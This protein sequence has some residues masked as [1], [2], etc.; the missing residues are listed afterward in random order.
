MKNGYFFCISINETG[1]KTTKYFS[2]LVKVSNMLTITDR[3]L[4]TNFIKL[5]QR[6]SHVL[7]NDIFSNQVT[8]EEVT[9]YDGDVGTIL[10]LFL[11][12]GKELILS[13]LEGIETT[14]DLDAL[15]KKLTALLYKAQEDI[16][17]YDF[18]DVLSH[19]SLNRIAFARILNN[20]WQ[21]FDNNSSVTAIR[22]E[23]LGGSPRA[24][25]TQKPPLREW[26]PKIVEIRQ[27]GKFELRHIDFEDSRKWKAVLFDYL[28]NRPIVVEINDLYF[29]E[30]LKSTDE[31]QVN[32][33]LHGDI[34]KALYTTEYDPLTDKTTFKIIEVRDRWRRSQFTQLDLPLD[35]DAAPPEPSSEPDVAKTSKK[36][37][38]KHNSWR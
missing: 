29:L 33:I 15:L 26:L 2:T 7:H 21:Y 11:K 36:G 10:R 1:R 28:H 31:N 27:E 5:K 20:I 19:S 38:R 14:A 24:L 30:S 8:I 37:K 25:F 18:L 4:L 9:A 12:S 23:S 13:S 6:F 16:K 34:I 35:N 32:G 22:I 3:F 17:P